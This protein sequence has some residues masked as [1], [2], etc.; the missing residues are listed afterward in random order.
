VLAGLLAC[1]VIGL[2]YGMAQPAKTDSEQPVVAWLE[3]HHLTTG[4]G[5]YAESNV[6]TMDSGGRVAVRTVAWQLPRA[7]PRAYESKASWYDPRLSYAN[8]VLVNEADAAHLP[9]QDLHHL[10][11]EPQSAQRPWRPA[12]TVPRRRSLSRWPATVFLVP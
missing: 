7:V 10:G 9:L 2:G 5:T 12:V 11:L 8:F 4:L 6:I 1:Y 3:A